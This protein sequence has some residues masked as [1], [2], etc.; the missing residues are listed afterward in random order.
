MM[1]KTEFPMRH[2]FFSVK[3]AISGAAVIMLSLFAQSMISFPQ[4]WTEQPVQFL[5]FIISSGLT[6]AIASGAVLVYLYP[7]DQDVIGVAALGSDDLTQHIALFLVITSLIEPILAGFVFFYE[8][9]GTDPFVIIWVMA[10]FAAP[11]IGFTVSMF[12]RT[13]A[14][15]ADLR[16]HFTKHSTLDLSE[17]DWLHGLGP[18]TSVYRMGMLENAA[19]KVEG[20]RIRGHLLVKEKDQFVIPS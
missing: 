17:L 18:R 7:P 3:G 15:A 8:Y 20:L 4:V 13:S 1:S 2:E 12:D 19:S 9:F 14:I 10:G 11:S 6:V 5:G 16:R